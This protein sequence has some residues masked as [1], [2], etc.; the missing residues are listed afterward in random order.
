MVP[1][2]NEAGNLGA[3]VRR[4]DA[5]LAGRRYEILIVDDDSCD[6]TAQICANL[7]GQYPLELLVR[8]RPTDGLSGAAILGL[9]RAR[10]EYLVVI[11][12]DLQ[13]PPERIP[14]LL[15]PLARRE[16]DFVLGSRYV[17]GGSTE[18]QWGPLRRIN[19]RLATLLARPFAANICDPMSGFFALKRE[20]YRRAG[21]L[22]PVGYKIAL[23]LLCKCR[24]RR[25]REVPIHFGLRAGGDSKLTVGQQ[26]RYLEHLSRLYD[27]KFPGLS[28]FL[29]FAI[30]TLLAWLV[31]FG[32][33]V[34]LVAHDV[35]PVMAP[36]LAFAAAA[37]ATAAFHLRAMRTAGTRRRGRDWFDWAAVILG[38]WSVCTL[39]AQWVAYHIAHAS[40]LAVFGFA[41]GAA[42]V[43]RF[44]LRRRLLHN[45]KG[46][47]P[48]PRQDQRRDQLPKAA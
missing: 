5:A 1:A 3:L 11:D 36:T 13:H 26:V 32:A 41:F 2:L 37:L 46:V 20:T 22:N 9:S 44:T 10:G 40:M 31:A 18:R 21:R 23:E 7:A 17:P 42:A 25:V 12:A 29:K 45:L 43:A 8:R 34:R 48:E 47:R 6:G 33:Y 39:A 19:S 35:G 24:V 30:T 28:P 14:D 4:V 16:A 38:E 27:F 15:A